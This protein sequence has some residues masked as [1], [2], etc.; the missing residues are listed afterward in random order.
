MHFA[1]RFGEEGA[2]FRLA[3]QLEKARPWF[4]RAP[5]GIIQ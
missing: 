3:G 2:L 1:G 5:S 4:D